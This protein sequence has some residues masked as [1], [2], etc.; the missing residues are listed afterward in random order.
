MKLPLPS[1]LLAA[2]LAA[3]PAAAGA[4]EP[5]VA[6]TF[7]QGTPADDAG[8]YPATLHNGAEIAR[9]SDG[10][11][12]LRLKDHDGYLELGANFG[13]MVLGSLRSK[14]Y[15]FS[16]D[17]L[18][19]E[20]DHALSRAGN[21]VFC[22]SSTTDNP[23]PPN[24]YMMRVPFGS[25]G[26]TF[27]YSDNNYRVQGT[28]DIT[29][30][31]WQTL[32]YVRS[33]DTATF[34]LN[35]HPAAT[36]RLTGNA[37]E[38]PAYMIEQCGIY[39]LDNYLGRSP[40]RGDSYL[41]NA[42][43]DN[44]L[45]YD[46]A[47]APA[48][49]EA[50]YA[51]ASRRATG[52]FPRTL[53]TDRYKLL[54]AAVELAEGTAEALPG[55]DFSDGAEGDLLAAARRMVQDGTGDMQA[56]RDLALR[57][58]RK[59]LALLR[60]S[61]AS[62]LQNRCI[63]LT[64]ALRNPFL[65]LPATPEAAAD[66]AEWGCGWSGNFTLAAASDTADGWRD[67]Y[68]L[69]FQEDLLAEQQLDSLPRGIYRL[70]ARTSRRPNVR[71][72]LHAATQYGEKSVPFAE[73]ADWEELQWDSIPNTKLDSLYVTD[74]RLTIRLTGDNSLNRAYADE[75]RLFLIGNIPAGYEP[76][77]PG[78]GEVPLLPSRETLP[79]PE[80][81]VRLIQE[82]NDSWIER[83]PNPG[84]YQWNRGVYQVGNTKAALFLRDRAPES[85]RRYRE[86]ALKWA[87]N[88][89][90]MG[91]DSPFEERE[92]W[93][94]DYGTS[95]QYVLFGD[96]QIC[97]QTYIDLFSTFE[98]AVDTKYLTDADGNGRLDEKDM[99]ARAREVMGYQ[100]RTG[101]DDYW[102][103]TDGL[104]M[105]M[106]VMTRMHSLTGSSRF[107]QAME[108]YF[109]Y[110]RSAMYDEQR[111][112]FY[113]DGGYVYPAHATSNG[114]PDFWSR[115]A[116]WSLAALAQT[117]EMMPDT[118]ASYATY[119]QV[120]RDEC[121]A[122]AAWQQQDAA[123]RGYW[124]QSVCDP[125]YVPG[126]ETSGT[127]LDT[128][129]M[130]VGLRKGWLEEEQY[131]PVVK[132]GWDYLVQVALQREG[133]SRVPYIGY[134][135]PIG[136]AATSSTPA[137]SEQDFGTGAFL[138]AAVEMVRYTEEKL[139]EDPTGLGSPAT[140]TAIADPDA[141]VDVFTAEGRP[142]R[143]AVR[144]GADCA[145]ALEGLPAGVY[146]VGREKRAKAEP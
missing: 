30:G 63:N 20:D 110:C 100:I 115:A 74:G 81:V 40:W 65:L 104:F 61:P 97:F 3:A 118:A 116:G 7:E 79:E 140:E 15:S 62:N 33:G 54:R 23:S 95:S 124:T 21:F 146:I 93:R 139:A 18:V 45:V 14:E 13:M 72:A 120:Y 70:E 52:R 102:W 125:A 69:S 141:R 133:D 60:K 77:L 34:Y 46:R 49:V 130:L 12:V 123:G 121:R 68:F 39:Y 138:L 122:L 98:P 142:L 111:H 75:F 41:K 90:W 113:R 11:H 82:V 1:L 117:L 16:V 99:V 10:N 66:T 119:M 58:S 127:A 9:F 6:Y 134:V 57:I 4:Q 88:N 32:S 28:E 53:P 71:K 80:S 87:Q 145:E 38:T 94:H 96:N 44:F 50:L 36:A 64:A 17:V 85:A 24:Y 105:V 26:F 67:G 43:I 2:A 135:Q 8:R 106:P 59:A 31:R 136:A 22:F 129:A 78:G 55:A 27:R 42:C 37:G 83:H 132:R 131:F 114:L 73:G 128:Y 47:L 101:R 19:D 86:Y 107:L 56:A 51:A 29:P 108:R 92:N 137:S 76:P 91:A 126:Y 5:L 35:G 143:R 48:E 103:W 89:R 84:D 25:T 144:R 109:A 112:I